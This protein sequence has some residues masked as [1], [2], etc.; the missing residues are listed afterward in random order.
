MLVVA[1]LF[2]CQNACQNLCQTMAERAVQCGLSVTQDELESCI[3]ENEEVDEARS[4]QCVDADDPLRLEEWWSCDE[5]AE[6]Y[7]HGVG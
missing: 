1:L 4:A 3:S 5:F 6:N 7:A 2:G